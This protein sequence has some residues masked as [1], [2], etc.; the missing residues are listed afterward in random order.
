MT[1]SFWKGAIAVMALAPGMVFGMAP[2]LLAAQEPTGAQDKI[3]NERSPVEDGFVEL[4]ERVRSFTVNSDRIDPYRQIAFSVQWE[5]QTIPGVNYVSPLQRSTE[6]ISYREG[7]G[8]T[9]VRA[10]PGLTTMAPV[11]L[12]RGVTHDPAFED[13]ASQVWNPQGSEA[14]SLEKYRKDILVDLKN[15][16]GQIVK[17]YM[18][19]RCWPTEYAAIEA[20]DAASGLVAEERLVLQ[21]DSWSRDK[22]VSEP[23]QR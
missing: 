6:A 7:N 15:L 21:C 3:D 12:K 16:N 22:A 20:L 10:T 23:R 13:W 9:N 14:G 4:L 5:G 19:F 8:S 18:L 2:G 1:K 11:T 17:R